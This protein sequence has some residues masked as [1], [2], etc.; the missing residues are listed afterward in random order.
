[1][2][3]FVQSGDTV[4]VA[5]PSGGVSSGQ[6]ILIG[7]LFGVAA[8]TQDAGDDVEIETRGVFDLAKVNGSEFTPGAAAYW[9]HTA[10][11]VTDT[12]S[13]AGDPRIGVALEVAGTSA[14]T[15][16][17]RLDGVVTV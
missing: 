12:A 7:V 14:A 16:R 8:T 4:T 9:D 5:A 6:G 1:M 13:T 15:V 10:K 11:A 17:C 3:N 2:K